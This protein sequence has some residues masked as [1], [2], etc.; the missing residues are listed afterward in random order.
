MPLSNGELAANGISRSDLR[1]PTVVRGLM[2]HEQTEIEL[3]EEQKRMQEWFYG[4]QSQKQTPVTLKDQT[5][6]NLEATGH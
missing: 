5:A 6:S 2:E 3:D 1:I 4:S